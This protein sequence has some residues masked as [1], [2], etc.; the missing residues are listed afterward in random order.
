MTSAKEDGTAAAAEQLGSMSLG[1]AA[2]RKDNDAAEPNAENRT[3]T[4]TEKL[5]SACGK[6]SDA[7]KKCTACKC[8]WYCD[9]M[10][11]KKRRK[12]HIKECK[13]IKKWWRFCYVCSW[14]FSFLLQYGTNSNEP[15]PE[16]HE[17]KIGL[18]MKRGTSEVVKRWKDDPCNESH[19]ISSSSSS[20]SL[21]PSL[22]SGEIHKMRR[23]IA[24]SD[25]SSCYNRYLPAFINYT[26]NRME[27]VHNHLNLHIPKSGGTSICSLA[28]QKSK[29]YTNF[30]VA[31][32]NGCWEGDHFLPLWCNPHF[33]P[34]GDRSEWASLDNSALC[35]MMDRNLSMFVMNENYLDHPLCT[36]EKIYSIVLR[37]PV[38][39]VMSNERHLLEFQRVHHKERVDLIRNNYI[40]WALSSGTT[41]HGK[42]LSVLPQRKHLEI[43]KETLLQFDYILD[44]TT[45]T[46]CRVDVLYLMGLASNGDSEKMPHEMKGRGKQ[47]KLALSRKEYEELNL[48]DIEL[49]EYA[50]SVMRVDCEFFSRLRERINE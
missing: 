23:M 31:K 28:K 3:T 30:T 27:H 40:V 47:W 44:V 25:N 21:F 34:G 1:T 50:Q 17:S 32:T 14:A 10:C 45:S 36:Q 24:I 22:S 48:L 15:Q 49:H 2:E 5:C 16:L 35:N 8:V 39:R 20:S 9:T 12:E 41:A 4:P 11:Q 46:S 26:L 13:R 37:D 6:T 7:V 38:D 18:S 43:A 29:K 42:R 19:N 33:V